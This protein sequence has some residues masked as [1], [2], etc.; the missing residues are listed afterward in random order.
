MAK[1]AKLSAEAH[2]DHLRR[3]LDQRAARADLPGPSPQFADTPSLYSPTSSVFSPYSQGYTPN[4]R[5]TLSRH[6]NATDSASSMLDLDDDSRPSSFAT[7]HHDLHENFEDSEDDDEE[8]EEEEFNPRMSLLG[9]KM[10]FHSR[11]PWETGGEMLEEEEEPGNSPVHDGAASTFEFATGRVP[12]IEGIKKFRFGS[13]KPSR[14]SED[15]ESSRSQDKYKR[16]FETVS[17]HTSLTSQSHSPSV[18]SL[19]YIGP[20]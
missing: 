19:K 4:S 1:L 7:A 8:E 13:S 16:S 17:S 9:P 6:M 11:A 12:N 20:Y 10:R 5:Y 14:P 3:L 15:S 2:Q 18:S